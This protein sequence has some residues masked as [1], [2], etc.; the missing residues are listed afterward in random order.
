[1][2]NLVTI[3]S[4]VG[5]IPFARPTHSIVTPFT[6]ALKRITDHF[7]YYLIVVLGEI[8]EYFTSIT[9][10]VVGARVEVPIVCG[11]DASMFSELRG[12]CVAVTISGDHS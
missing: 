8:A 3:E 11:V 10:G 2:F 6:S 5:T 1:M 7:S 9:S 12:T 4:T